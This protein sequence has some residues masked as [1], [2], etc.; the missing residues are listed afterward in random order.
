MANWVVVVLVVAA[1]VL[2]L[3]LVLASLT[4][5]S[6]HV[7]PLRRAL[8]RLSWRVEEAQ[9]LQVKVAAVQERIVDLEA[10]LPRS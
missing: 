8:R 7:R 3:A 9:Q 2:G 5:L 1:V 10:N 6:G 4:A